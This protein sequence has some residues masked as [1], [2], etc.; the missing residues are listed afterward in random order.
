MLVWAAIVLMALSSAFAGAWLFSKTTRTGEIASDAALVRYPQ[1]RAVADFPLIDHRGEPFRL[2]ETRGAWS[3]MF[4]GFT[5]CPD[6]C[7]DTLYKMARV[8]TALGA[9]NPNGMGLQWY[10][11]AV[12]TERDTPDRIASYLDYFDAGITGL[13]GDPAILEGMAMQL[14]IAFRIEPHEPGAESYNVDHSAGLV[15]LDP[16]GRLYGLLRPPHDV[17]AM[18][19]ALR[20]LPDSGY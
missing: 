18:A 14:G 17:D 9:M 2:S 7:P 6:V 5:A 19:A 4:F 15:V 12:D 3:L 20:S 16:D 11:V 1:P 8:R 13:T 10:F